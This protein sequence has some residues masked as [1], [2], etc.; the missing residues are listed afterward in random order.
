MQAGRGAQGERE[1]QVDSP[2]SMEPDV[3]LDLSN[4]EIMT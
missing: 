2:P 1:S 3:G 4:P